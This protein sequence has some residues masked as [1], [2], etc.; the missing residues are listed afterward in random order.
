MD[1]RKHGFTLIELLVVIAI[2]ALLM[3]IMMPALSMVK[4]MAHATICQGNL[5]HW[6]VCYEM[7]ADDNNDEVCGDWFDDL[8]KYFKDF[9]FLLC[10]AARRKGHIPEDADDPSD[11]HRRGGKSEAWYLGPEEYE[12]NPGRPDEVVRKELLGS[13]GGNAHANM[14][15][16]FTHPDTDWVHLR[17]KGLGKAPVLLDAARAAA[18]PR[19]IDEP[20]EYDDQ[21]YYS[22]VD[23]VSEIRI[24]SINRHPG[25]TVNSLF[26]DFHVEKVTLK[27]L[28]VLEWFR[29]WPCDPH[30][31]YKCSPPALLAAL[32]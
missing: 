15:S 31:N 22:I 23:D 30:I 2:I 11:P 25:Y 10:P 16:N 32:V 4:R 29:G 3:S 12:L 7:F 13:Y 19:P 26:L 20:P 5:R 6:G 14:G 24:F 18:V 28:F 8:A 1:K 27:E 17:Q 9:E 21:I